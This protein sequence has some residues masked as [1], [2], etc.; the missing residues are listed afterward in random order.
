LIYNRSAGQASRF[1]GLL[2]PKDKQYV[3]IQPLRAAAKFCQI[4]GWI[5]LARFLW[6]LEAVMPKIF[7]SYRRGNSDAITGRIR[8]RL[9]HRYGEDSVFMDLDNI[10]GGMDFRARIDQVL[11]EAQAVIAVVGPKWIGPSKGGIPRIMQDGDWVR[12]ELE[13]ALQRNLLVV[14]VLVE[15][16]EMPDASQ[17]PPGLKSFAYRQAEV[18][19]SG[20]DFGVHIERLFRSIDRLVAKEGVEKKPVERELPPPEV[21]TPASFMSAAPPPATVAPVAV[22]EAPAQPTETEETAPAA[23]EAELIPIT[24]HEAVALVEPTEEV[25]SASEGEEP[26]TGLAARDAVDAVETEIPAALVSFPAS[27]PEGSAGIPSSPEPERAKR[28]FVYQWRYPAGIAAALIAILLGGGV[29]YVFIRS[30]DD[31]ASHD[32]K[33][34]PPPPDTPRKM[35]VAINDP[36]EKAVPPPPR[37]NCLAGPAAAVGGPFSPA[38]IRPNLADTKKI[39]AVAVSPTGNEIATAGDDGLVR[40]WDASSFKLLRTLSGHSDKVY[41]LNYWGDGLRLASASW[42]GTVRIWNFDGKPM[43]T[44]DTQLNGGITIK[45][46]SVAFVPEP[47]KDASPKYVVSG[48]EDGNVRKWSIQSGRLEEKKPSAAVEEKKQPGAPKERNPQAVQALSFE[49]N[50]TG[51]FVAGAFDGRIRVFQTTPTAPVELSANTKK[52]LHVAYSPDGKSIVSAGRNGEG[53]VLNAE[54]LKIWNV[55]SR[56]FRALRGHNDYVVSASWS[57]DGKYIV[58]GGG[59]TDNRV[60]LWNAD[61]TERIT[62]FT[63]TGHFKDVESVAFFADG[64]RIISAGEDGT[65]RIWDVASGKE[66]LT[67]VTYGENEHLLYTPAGCYSGSPGIEKRLNV[68]FNNKSAPLSREDLYVPPGGFGPLFQSR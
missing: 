66:I 46:Y 67:A 25:V 45:Q 3:K 8:D 36:P 51:E 22:E 53:P 43:Q 59:E 47:S 33:I 44:F 16:A 63:G 4:C 50:G 29:Y 17:L 7:I 31:L 21:I 26:P 15:G 39:R 20:R 13:P 54:S 34:V 1:R 41:S 9:A 35:E 40:I 12:R 10:L 60:L 62:S 68:Y 5:S 32:T 42:D 23:T 38:S 2:R 6:S 30:P 37:S 52:A 57:P 64:S 14:P 27:P 49:P 56:S 19:A 58:S 65:I 48:G 18:V 24:E 61:T 11:G 28:S 55:K